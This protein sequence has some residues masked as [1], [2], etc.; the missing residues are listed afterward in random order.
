MGSLVTGRADA[1]AVS[2]GGAD[3]EGGRLALNQAQKPKERL[4]SSHLYMEKEVETS[5]QPL[6][7]VQDV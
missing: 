5:S 7:P 1:D 6:E 3:Q 4:K 2:I